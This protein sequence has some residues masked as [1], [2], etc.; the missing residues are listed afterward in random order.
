VTATSG[1]ESPGAS[2]LS[3]ARPPPAPAPAGAWPPPLAPA[4]AWPPPPPAPNGGAGRAP[5]AFETASP[6]GSQASSKLGS[7]FGGGRGA[8][9]PGDASLARR[10]AKLRRLEGALAAREAALARREAEHAELA[11]H[12]SAGAPKNWPLPPWFRW[13]RHDIAADVPLARAGLVRLSYCGF[14]FATA[15]YIWN[16]I[17]MTALF[18][19]DEKGADLWLFAALVAVCGVPA[20]FLGWHKSLY[21]VAADDR[22]R[23]W[24]AF[25]LYLLLHIVWCVWMFL[26]VKPKIG[27][28]SA[29]LFEVLGW[30]STAL[31]I[32][33]IINMA[34]WAG[35]GVLANA[36]LVRGCMVFRGRAGA[37]ARGGRVYV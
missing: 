6:P 10:E 33:C 3:V 26:G 18:A 16:W 29:G 9:P 37:P 35:A 5:A 19:D 32:L 12:G 31:G 30:P 25:F 27:G 2:P 28:F 7:F 11:A 20:S 14:L 36:V 22:A 17:A 21:R 8:A 34:L 23:R 1:L 4:S 15:A 24:I 13:A